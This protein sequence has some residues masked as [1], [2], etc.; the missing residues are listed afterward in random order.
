MPEANAGFRKLKPEL[1]TLS[2]DEY[3]YCCLYL[4]KQFSPEKIKTILQLDNEK[5]K[6]IKNAMLDKLASLGYSLA[7]LKTHH[8]KIKPNK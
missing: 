3:V 2:D 8:I 5:A 6:L 7:Y 4:T 1:H